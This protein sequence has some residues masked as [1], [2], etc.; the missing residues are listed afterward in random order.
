MHVPT[1]PEEPRK[2]R[3]NPRWLVAGLMLS[4]LI[5]AAATAGKFL[6]TKSPAKTAIRTGPPAVKNTSQHLLFRFE[7]EGRKGFF[8]LDKKESPGR[9]YW[10]D[11]EF[12]R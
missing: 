8:R 10:E 3:P 1:L 7:L 4:L 11:A 5:L 6:Q 12:F 9:S 2:F